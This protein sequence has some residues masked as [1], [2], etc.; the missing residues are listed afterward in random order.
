MSLDFE[1]ELSVRVDTRR[2]AG[3]ATKPLS[4]AVEFFWATSM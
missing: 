2:L 3:I 4:F 1:M